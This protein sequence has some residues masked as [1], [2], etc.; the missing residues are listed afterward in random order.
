MAEYREA[1]RTRPTDVAANENLLGIAMR[2]QEKLREAIAAFRESIRLN[3]DFADAH[4][5]LARTLYRQE[6]AVE[7]IPEFREALRLDPAH[8]AARKELRDALESLGGHN[9]VIEK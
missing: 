8:A 3:P 1:I 9:D 4:Y 5:N 6:K 2:C 7:A